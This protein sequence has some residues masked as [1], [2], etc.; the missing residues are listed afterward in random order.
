MGK[1]ASVMVESLKAG[2]ILDLE[3]RPTLSE[4]PA[5]GVEEDAVTFEL[6]QTLIDEF[7]LVSE[8]EIKTALKNFLATQHLLIEGA[9]AVVLAAF[10][11]TRSKYQ[12]KK[13]ALVICGANIGLEDLKTVL[14]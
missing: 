13:V 11:K 2:E 6:C 12:G 7:V 5:G 9:A 3:S 1:M 4:G 8:D 10:E 14:A